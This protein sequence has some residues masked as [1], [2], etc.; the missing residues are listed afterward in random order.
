MYVECWNYI[1]APC[2]ALKNRIVARISTFPQILIHRILLSPPY[3]W[4]LEIYLVKAIVHTF[5]AS[6]FRN[7][8]NCCIVKLILVLDGRFNATFFTLLVEH[9]QRSNEFNFPH[10]KGYGVI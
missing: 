4:P 6:N 3:D 5:F 1:R 7:F 9:K 2:D 8:R 10:L